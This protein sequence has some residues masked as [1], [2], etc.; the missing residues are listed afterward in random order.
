MWDGKEGCHLP[1]RQPRRKLSFPSRVSAPNFLSLASSGPLA[2]EIPAQWGHSWGIQVWSRAEAV[3]GTLGATDGTWHLAV[4]ALPCCPYPS[5]V[6]HTVDSMHDHQ[7]PADGASG[8]GG[9][10]RTPGSTSHYSL[11]Q[12][13][14]LGL[15]S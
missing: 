6:S 10:L 12:N 11:S 9:D 13:V 2:L 7:L 5:P 4:P 1:P 15:S 8:L 3:L 14:S